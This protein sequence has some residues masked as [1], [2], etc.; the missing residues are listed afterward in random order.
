MPPDLIG[1]PRL[2]MEQLLIEIERRNREA[3]SPKMELAR[4]FPGNIIVARGGRSAG[5]KT[6]GMVS[7]NVQESHRTEQRVVCLRETYVSLEESM[8]EA[9]R[10]CVD[11]LEFPGWHFAPSQ[12]FIR[13][14]TGSKWVFR[15]L[16]NL[17]AAKATKGLQGFTRF[18]TD[19]AADISGPSLDIL[20]PTVMKVRGSKLFAAY[21]PNTETDPIFSKVWK[22]NIS[23]PRA[24]LL[25]MRPGIED[26]PWFNEESQQ[27][28]DQLKADDPELW[29]HVW[30]GKPMAQGDR[31]VLARAEIRLAME[32]TVPAGN[33]KELGVDVA[34]FG[35]DKTVFALREGMRVTELREVAKMDTQEVARIAW[36]MVKRDRDV[37]IKV[38]DSGV[39][40]GVTDKLRDIGA[41]VVPV[42]F[43][44]KPK[45]DEKYTSAAD[46]MWFELKDIIDRIQLPDHD[47]L[48][49]ELGGR[50]YKYTSHDQRKVEPKDEFKKRFGRSPDYADATILCFY[51]PESSLK[52]SDAD[53]A[54]M[55]ARRN[56]GR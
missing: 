26:N 45:D 4:N 1:D 34:R 12:G 5:A 36:D 6:T 37:P 28:S 3:V 24:L 41:K 48:M 54:A 8:Y 50:Q 51:D 11:T 15:G 56:R 55:Q 46:E 40:G 25:D 30:G 27:L 7:L 32:R 29:E 20:L 17:R 31:S 9:V 22:P 47:K 18:L 53:R 35:D 39:G 13:S 33:V 49:E 38:D 23:N 2:E 14:P 19:E 42:N 44:G 16:A 43:G 21:N 52:M 10:E